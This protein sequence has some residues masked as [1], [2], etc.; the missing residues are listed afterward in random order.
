MDVHVAAFQWKDDTPNDRVD[1]ALRTV[2]SLEDLVPG[3]SHI[4]V[5]ENTS[6]WAKNYTHVV[7]VLGE[8]ADAIQAYR[9]HP[10]HVEVATEIEDMEL[11]GIG[12]DFRD[13]ES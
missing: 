10:V 6:K 11:D 13:L 12:L 7:V 9:D 1:E 2:K 8:S 3:I 4:H 5:G